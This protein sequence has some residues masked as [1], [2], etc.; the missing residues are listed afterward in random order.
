MAIHAGGPRGAHI[1]TFEDRREVAEGTMA[2]YFG[3][4]A[5]VDFSEY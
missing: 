2:C 5:G 4:P 1:V 3:K